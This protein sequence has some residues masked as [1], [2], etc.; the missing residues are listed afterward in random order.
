MLW[1]LLFLFMIGID[2]TTKYIIKS[3]FLVYQSINIIDNF[4]K[5]TYV[6]NNGIAFGMFQKMGNYFLFLTPLAIIFLLIFFYK[7]K[8]KNF[9]LKISFTLIIAGA[10]GNYIDRILYGY[11]IDFLDVD[12]F[13]I[14]IRP[15]QILSFKF[16]GYEL[17]RWP[18]FNFADSII[19][20]GV[21]LLFVESF[22][23]K[24]EKKNASNI[25]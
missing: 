9:L 14:V 3:H 1:F 13:N 16:Q 8:N 23:E 21:F 5:I 15:F 2:Y 7:T 19:S 22:F 25:I 11:V 24:K 17:Y 4:F 12:F 10:V 20:I 6:K 18:T